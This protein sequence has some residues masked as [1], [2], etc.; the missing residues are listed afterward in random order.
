MT[1]HYADKTKA[2]LAYQNGRQQKVPPK[3]LSTSGP[4]LLNLNWFHVKK[5]SEKKSRKTPNYALTIIQKT[6]R[7]HCSTRGR[8]VTTKFEFKQKRPFQSIYRFCS[9]RYGTHV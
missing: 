3:Y 9:S 8:P 4:Q 1:G 2:E 6:K 5:L 7:R